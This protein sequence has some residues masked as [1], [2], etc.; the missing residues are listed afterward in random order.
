[1]ARTQSFDHDT[2]VRAARTLFWS[3]GYESASIPELES[4]TGL[5][6]SSI[7]NAFGSK[8][9]LFDA[10]VQSYL[11]EVVRPRLQPLSAEPVARDAII[12]Y[13]Q[14]LHDAFGTLTSMPASH[15]CLLVNAAGAPIAQDPKVARVIAD[16][17][18]ELRGAFA[19]GVQA[20]APDLDAADRDRLVDA[21]T[22][23]VVAAFALARIDPAEAARGL[24]SAIELLA[25]ESGRARAGHA[26]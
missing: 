5:S 7:Y 24:A 3:V 14:G 2:V 16:Y 21:I 10:A 17:R 23:S 25:R 8:R 18:A 11:D 9:G 20:Y 1:M 4:A 19:R 12:A 6:R 13:L 22:S 26:A 15:G